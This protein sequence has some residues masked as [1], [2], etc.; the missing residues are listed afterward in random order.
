MQINHPSNPE[1]RDLFEE[2]GN[3]R[4]GNR[5]TKVLVN[6]TEGDL[7]NYKFSYGTGRPGTS[8]STPRHHHEFEQIRYVLEGDYAI[9]HKEVL[10]A[11]SVAYFPEA[12]YYGPQVLE[13]N[14]VLTTAQFGGP[15]GFGYTSVRQRREAFDKLL[16]AGG[17][18][19]EGIYKTVDADGKHHNQDGAE[20]IWETVNGRPMEYPEPRYAGLIKMNPANFSWLPMDGQPGVHHKPLGSFTE[21]D[22]RVGFVKVES[23]ASF[24]FGNPASVEI[25]F[26]VEGSVIRDGQSHPKLTAFASE[27]GE[28]PADLAAETTT[29]F[30]YMKLPTF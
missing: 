22:V 19:E 6:G 29:E 13:S 24:S 10:P 15:S 14:V 8:W 2:G 16:A 23:G 27:K 28:A 26:L 11:G 17:T 7:S 21:R 1:L 20:A 12:A 4:T 30:L 9:G 5:D 3:I 18:F 25:L